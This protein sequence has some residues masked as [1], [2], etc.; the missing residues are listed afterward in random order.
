M[1]YLFLVRHG[2]TDGN[3]DRIS[4][5]PDTPLSTT[6]LQQAEELATGLE[7]VSIATVLCSPHRRTQQ[8]IA[9]LLLQ[10]QCKLHLDELLTERSFGDWR[11]TAYDQLPADLF[12]SNHQPKNGESIS[13]FETRVSQ[14]WNMILDKANRTDGNTLVMTHGL[15]LRAVL[16]HHL[17]LEQADLTNAGFHNTCVT[18]VRLGETLV[19]EQLC[20]TAHLSQQSIA[21]LASSAAV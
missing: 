2:Q 21:S 5:S 8:T 12:S 17:N 10:R 7:Q 3:R 16:T 20:D 4:Q 11:G 6:G 14:A 18:Q 13:Q 1:K 19:V 15:F 9:P